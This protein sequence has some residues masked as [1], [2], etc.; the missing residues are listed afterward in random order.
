MSNRLILLIV[1]FLSS[2]TLLA[3]K[4]TVSGNIKDG[5]N[6]EDL[7]DAT[8]LVKELSNTG[9]KS[10]TYGF[11][12]LTLPAG[13]YTLIYRATGYE[14]K[15]ITVDLQ[16]NKHI[17][18][19]LVVKKDVKELA[20]V[21]VTAVKE[22]DNITKSGM[23]VTT[24]SPKDIETIPVLFGEKDI[25]KTLQLTPGVKSAG[26]GNAGFYVR[27]G[28]ADQ[29]L[30]LLD[31]APVY[32]ASHLLGFFSVFNSDAIKDVSLYKSGIPAEFGGRASSVLDVKMRE[33]N[34]KRYNVSG[35][36]GLIASRLTVEGPIVKDKGSFIV[37]GRR[38]YMD[39]F[40][41]ASKKPELK[42]TKLYFYDL[43]L[44]AN[45]QV[46][47]KDRI[48]LSGY[49]GRDNFSFNDL[50]GFKWGNGTG[51][52]RW[53]RIVG[54]KM[55]SNTSFVFSNFNYSFDIS[56]GGNKLGVGAS[57]QDLNLKQDFDY[58]VNNS[59]ALKFGF[60]VIY[61]TFKPGELKSTI[62]AINNFKIDDQ[63]ALE[64]G[65][66]AQND[67]KIGNWLSIMY[68]IR[69]SG[70]DYM[71]KGTAYEYD[72]KG[73]KLSEQQYGSF[74]TIK[75]HHF[76]EPRLS[77]S[78]ILSEKNSLKIAYNRNSQY[79]HQL[80]NS[81][82]SS[83]TD[84]WVP[85]TNNVKP[86]IADQVAMGYYRNF[87]DNMLVLTTE[88]YYKHLGNQIDYRNG[89]SLFLNNEIEGGLVYGKGQTF[90]L[91]I[92]LEKKK[93]KFT[94]WISYTLS[95][96]LRKFNDI[97]MGKQFP[98]RQDRIHDLAVVAM[99]R[100]SQKI[101]LSGTFVFYTGDAVTFPSGK[102]EINGA[103]IPYY[104]ER[105]G[106]RMPNYHRLDLGLT[107]YFKDRPKFE[108]NLNVSIYNV[109]A[110]RNAFMISFEE[111]ED[112]PG[113]TKA[114]KTSLFRLVPSITYNFKIK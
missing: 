55:F 6:G 64:F 77:L 87:F 19:E 30:V 104:T 91:E 18:I 105:N 40:L 4:F 50:F 71:G 83:P 88:I 95:R 36:I 37:S 3:Q 2:L 39:L 80:S 103:V 34:Y 62:P 17:S 94:G 65:V 93:G 75:Y 49:F 26:D 107:V 54:K 23:A 61:H 42:N 24:L 9:S 70:F 58:Y 98:A 106:Y 5:E 43:N 108:H 45:Y 78:F 15:E 113:K 32:N 92:Q 57:I 44:K 99:Y 35:G 47:K 16:E 74:K 31:E 114:I 63:Y 10:N 29:N 82:S 13:T 110:Q 69:Y 72:E 89:A 21:E 84:I 12:S 73:T 11:Y 112:N 102:Y 46:S 109:Y 59:N 38:T 27:G 1:F 100:A 8:V 52:F 66:Y 48:Y 20:E 67:Q 101:A 81:S 79:L 28:G 22:N 90:G 60:N 86:Q 85:S 51:T 111:D 53:N 25:V 96:S 41:K 33:G 97:N 68:G 14:Q 76:I 56:S 7:F